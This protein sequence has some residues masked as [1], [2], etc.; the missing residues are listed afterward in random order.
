MCKEKKRKTDPKKARALSV[1]RVAVWQFDV[2]EVSLYIPNFTGDWSS[3]S[4]ASVKNK[5]ALSR[6]ERAARSSVKQSW[7]NHRGGVLAIRC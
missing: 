7:K 5:V 4:Q 2:D 6:G 1:F 3:G